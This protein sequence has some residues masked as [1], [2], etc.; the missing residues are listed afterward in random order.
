MNQTYLTL[1]SYPIILIT[2]ILI[3][4][5]LKLVDKPSSRKIHSESI[6]NTSGVALYIFLFFIISTNEFSY[7]LETVVAIGLFVILIGFIDDRIDLTPGIKLFFKSIAVV[8]LI[9]NGFNLED[10]GSY[11]FFQTINLGKFAFVFTFLAALL[12]MN[13]FNYIDGI[14]GL[15]FGTTITALLY[16]IFLTNDFSNYI[17]LFLYLL[18]ALL[19]NLFF[20]MLPIR[21]KLKCFSG[22]AG[23]LFLGFFISFSIIFLYKKH[24]IHPAFLIWSCWYSVYDFIYVTFIR[25]IKQK[26]F[27]KADKTHFHHQVLKYFNNNQIKSSIVINIL[28]ICIIGTGYCITAY[29]GKIFSLFFFIILF[30]VFILTRKKLFQSTQNY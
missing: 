13:A 29:I 30:F 20:N 22:N 26:K 14:D 3:S 2:I 12:L 23:S 18:Y 8:Y 1:L 11:E 15:L 5:K 10:L 24:N 21:S 19:V 27:T 16:F 28:N 9:F 6:V 17:N 7:E 4:N 25:I